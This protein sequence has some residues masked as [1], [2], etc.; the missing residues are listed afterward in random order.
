MPQVTLD[1]VSLD[2]KPL[3]GV[4]RRF[5]G[6]GGTI[7]RDEGNTL[8]LP[9]PN[10]RVS[11]LH[12][13]ISF[14][15]G[16][17]TITNS[18]SVLSIGVGGTALGCG[19]AMPLVPGTSLNIGPY[20]L[21][22]RPSEAAAPPSPMDALAASHP[23][24]V[25]PVPTAGDP[26]DGLLA[27][28]G[29][30]P[31]VH[32]PATPA[33]P[34]HPVNDPLADLLAGLGPAPAAPRPATPVPPLHPVD[35]PLAGLLGPG[36][37]APSL[38]H[39]SAAA[40]GDPF[41]ALGAASGAGVD[42]RRQQPQPLP[43]YSPPAAAI[44]PEDFNPFDLPSAA[45][46]NSPDP[47]SSLLDRSD[48]PQVHALTQGEESIDALFSPAGAP[49][50]DEF[51]NGRIGAGPFGG[52]ASGP[53]SLLAPAEN[54]DPLALFGVSSPR[55][56]SS[57][58]PMRDDLAEIGGAYQPPRALD[59]RLSP[60]TPAKPAPSSGVAQSNPLQAPI[61]S[62]AEDALTRAFL[63]GANLPAGALPQGLTPEVMTMVGSL[64]RNATA[65]AIEMLAI[66]ANIKREVQA[67]VTII[68]TEANNPLKFL[69]DADSVLLQLLGKKMPG[70]M[71]PDEAMQD[72]FNDLRAHELG[73]I[74][75]TR[76]ALDEVLAKFDPAILGER[77]IRGSLLEMALP[78]MRKTKLWDL[79][80]ERY[81]QMRREVED[82]FQSVFGKAFVAAYE[83]ETA[84]MKAR[85]S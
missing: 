50:V 70:F 20:V 58:N 80:L 9:D 71:R 17:P 25:A 47:L 5:E 82:D 16:V 59:P 3:V 30:A 73:V 41:A 56:D 31:A 68:S 72:A 28:L 85:R 12:A 76:A 38:A 61:P 29:P 53:S 83:E 65:G 2:N 57:L 43:V 45:A 11:R 24:S 36:A 74:A 49:T 18:S 77:L 1:L 33:V 42:P 6:N 54:S 60:A 14:P 67:A 48:A 27:G 75:G 7:G 62:F 81:A 40:G 66:R 63:A 21:M 23:A 26:L 44:I 15:G 19:Q 35:D 34:L 13:T 78:A 22:V 8:P 84:R 51:S 39:G 37:A 10:R 79:Y 64:L 46:R 52:V 69:P 32:R 4:S 55:H